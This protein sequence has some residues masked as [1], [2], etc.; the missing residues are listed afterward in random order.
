MVELFLLVLL[1]AVI[2]LSIRHG[3]PVGQDNPLVILRPG[4]FHITLAPQLGRAQTFIEQI[5][6]QFALS[7]PP[8]G[9]LPTEYFEVDDSSGRGAEGGLY[10]LAAAY[11]GGLLY[12][13]AIVP[14]P[15]LR[16]ADSHMKQ[17]REFSEA[18]LVLHPLK[19]PARKA[20]AGKLRDAIEAAARYLKITV[21]MMPEAES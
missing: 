1:I 10:L 18:V 9:E 3:K 6:A 15:L 5:A 19:H 21:K 16:D 14:L 8:Q 12:F 13:Q 11:R 4:Q 7:H 17:M 20:E 2:V